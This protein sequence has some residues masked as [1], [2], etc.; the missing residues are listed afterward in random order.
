[1]FIQCSTVKRPG[2]DGRNRKLVEAYRDPETGRPRNRTVQKLEKLPILERARLI[3]RHG[4]RKYLDPEEWLAL[5]AA[6]DFAQVEAESVVG[7]SYRGA[8]SAVVLHHMRES[9]LD[10][11]LKRHC[12]RKLGQAIVDMMTLQ[13]LRPASKLRYVEDHK[14]TLSYLLGGKQEYSRQVFYRAVDALSEAFPA[15]RDELNA[16]HRSGGRLL[17]YDLSNSYF[18]GQKAELGGYG[19]SK[20]KRHDRYIVSYGLVMTEDNRP[21]DIRIWKGGT[22]DVKTVS[23]T[24]KDWKEKYH[25]GDAIW[26]ADRSMSSADTLSQVES[27]GLGYI[28]GLPP[29]QQQQLLANLHEGSPALFDEVLTEFRHEGRRYVL[30]RHHQ[31]GYRKERKSFQDRRE[32]YNALLRIQRSPQN[33]S[34]ERLYHRAMKV[35]EEHQQTKLWKIDF[36]TFTDKKGVPRYRLRI[37]L[38]RRAVIAQDRIGHFYILQTNLRG[39]QATTEEIQAFYKSLIHVERCF[40]TVKSDLEIRPIRHWRRARIEG[41]IYLNFL[42][43][44]LTKIIEKSW[45]ETQPGIEV[46]ATLRRWDDVLRLTELLDKENK[47]LIE[48]Q[49]NQGQQAEAVRAEIHAT[50]EHKHIMPPL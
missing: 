4:G 15:I 39:D 20:E 49:W 16:A 1:M 25:A 22:A 41:H 36:D 34:R 14:R 6:G 44:W 21:L 30:C 12:G 17:L 35:L 42:C 13:I 3:Y 18:C 48:L 29:G 23:E 2:K 11:I 9:G 8:G 5:E 47:S 40:R 31:K 10:G 32:I 27:L 24:F 46:T 7:D 37:T 33:K 26:V 45:R 43:L 38:N 28:T 50:G 19:D